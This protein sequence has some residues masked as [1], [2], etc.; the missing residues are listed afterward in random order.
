[1]ITLS[2]NMVL[3]SQPNRSFYISKTS[4]WTTCLALRRAVLFAGLG[5][6]KQKPGFSEGGSNGDQQKKGIPNQVI[7]RNFV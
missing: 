4:R 5:T 3:P 2:S 7:G 6:V 1:M